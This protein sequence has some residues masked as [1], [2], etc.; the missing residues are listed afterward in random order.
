MPVPRFLAAWYALPKICMNANLCCSPSDVI[1]PRLTF[2]WPKH[3]CLS[4]VL[5]HNTLRIG[6]LVSPPFASCTPAWQALAA[7]TP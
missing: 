6:L 3:H 2:G 7:E 4:A 1:L 5:H